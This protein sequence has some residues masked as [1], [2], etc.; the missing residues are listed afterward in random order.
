MALIDDLK[1]NFQGQPVVNR[2]IIINVA[3]FLIGYTVNLFA[4][5]ADLFEHGWAFHP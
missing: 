1:H 4:G 5:A 2:L 3:V